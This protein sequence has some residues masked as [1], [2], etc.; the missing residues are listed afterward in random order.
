MENN[1]RELIRQL[2]KRVA[3]TDAKVIQLVSEI[4]KLKKGTLMIVKY[5]EGKENEG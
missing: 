2:Q 5:L 4:E 3:A 1:N